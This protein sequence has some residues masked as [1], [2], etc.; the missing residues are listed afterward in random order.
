MI[1]LLIKVLVNQTKTLQNIADR[2]EKIN[3]I[4]EDRTN[5]LAYLIHN[6]YSCTEDALKEII[7][8][9]DGKS[10]TNGEGFHKDLLLHAKFELKGIRPCIISENSYSF[11]FEIL[12]FR[13]LFRHAYNYVLNPIKVKENKVFI[14]ENHTQLNEEL[15]VFISFLE[16]IEFN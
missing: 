1:E 7:K 2:I 10:I 3:P 9:F 15:K 4:D 11:L 6:Y 8:V 12:K 16:N 14:L 13:H 5:S